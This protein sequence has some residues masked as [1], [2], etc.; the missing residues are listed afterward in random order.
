LRVVRGA[1]AAV[2]AQVDAARTGQLETDAADAV[3][4]EALS[5][6]RLR[7]DDHEVAELRQAVAATADGFADIVR[8][9]PRA[10]AHE[11]GERVIE[12]VF[13]AR[14]REDGNAVGYDTIAAAG[15]H[16]NTLHWIRNDGV[17]RPGDLVLVDAGVEVDSLYTADVTRTLPVDG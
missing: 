7:K 12:G 3:L 6:L 4:T 15:N 16:A 13:G 1:D 10:V 14:A 17:V 5:E 8:S 2:E 9:L 11:R